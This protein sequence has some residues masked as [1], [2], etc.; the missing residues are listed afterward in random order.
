[1]LIKYVLISSITSNNGIM[2]YYRSQALLTLPLHYVSTMPFIP[3]ANWGGGGVVRQ[4][5][6]RFRGR[7]GT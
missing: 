7:F 6:L 4:L 5:Y 3:Y 2:I 1:M